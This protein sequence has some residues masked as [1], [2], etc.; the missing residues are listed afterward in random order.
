[1]QFHELIEPQIKKAITVTQSEQAII[2][3]TW[4]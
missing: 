3:V 1:M 2:L 4:L